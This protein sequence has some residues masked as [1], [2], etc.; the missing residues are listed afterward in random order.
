V[1]SCAV[2]VGFRPYGGM[3]K[4]QDSILRIV[5][6]AERIDLQSSW[7]PLP[8]H[9]IST[10]ASVQDWEQQ[11]DAIRDEFLQETRKRGIYLR[12]DQL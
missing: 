10:R 6:D 2:A 3:L 11:S 4:K 8:H 12:N 7:C 5:G 9:L 1:E